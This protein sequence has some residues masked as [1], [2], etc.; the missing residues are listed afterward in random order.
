MNTFNKL[1]TITKTNK[2]L[3]MFF[4]PVIPETKEEL[5]SIIEKELKRQGTDVDLNFIDTSKITDMSYL[6]I[7]LGR[8]NLKIDKWNT[9]NVT[10]MRC[11]FCCA[12]YVSADLSK[13]DVS[14]VTD[15][16]I[17]FARAKSFNSD[18]SK[19]KV[20]KFAIMNCMFYGAI[21]FES[22]LSTWCVL[23]DKMLEDMFVQTPMENKKELHP[24]ITNS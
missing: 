19:W 6:F 18:L 2:Y 20:S 15:M 14:K 3:N 16:F 7:N 12:T 5:E 13:W 24:K 23:D 11:M 9:S 1:I 21:N 10:N 22:N 17:M 4:R 8:R